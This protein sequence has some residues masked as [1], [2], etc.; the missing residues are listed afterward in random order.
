M[1]IMQKTLLHRLS[2]HNNQRYSMLTSG[3]DYD[4]NVVFHLKQL[5][6]NGLIEKIESNYLIT[7]E[8]IKIIS[9]YET[10]E[11]LNFGHKTFFVGLVCDDRDDNFLIKTHPQA[12]TPYFNLPNGGPHFGESM[13]TALLRIVKENLQCDSDAARFSFLSLHMKTVV[14]PEQEVLF[15]EGFAIY[16]VTFTTRLPDSHEYQW[17]PKEEII[18][19]ENRWPEIDLCILAPEVKPYASYQFMTDYILE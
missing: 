8:G 18:K 10:E 9:E 1:H 3:Y 2:L 11:L 7:P 17:M 14:T 16:K 5:V 4:D 19:L 15:D 6:S 13:D 12:K